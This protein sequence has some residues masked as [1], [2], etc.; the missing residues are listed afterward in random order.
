[1]KIEDVDVDV[2]SSNFEAE[3]RTIERGSKH[4]YDPS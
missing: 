4:S 2:I 1:L 3:K